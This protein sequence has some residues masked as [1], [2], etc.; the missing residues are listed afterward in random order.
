ME[1]H[2][3][4]QSA[5]LTEEKKKKTSHLLNRSQSI[6]ILQ[7]QSGGKQLEKRVKISVRHAA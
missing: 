2:G 7:I 6:R 1:N 3:R 5:E 4:P